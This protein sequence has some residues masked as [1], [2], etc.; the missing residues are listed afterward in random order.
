M[1]A[2][3]HMLSYLT[4]WPLA[5][6]S[7]TDESEIAQR[8]IPR[9]YAGHPSCCNPSD[10]PILWTSLQIICEKYLDFVLK[11]IKNRFNCSL[12]L[13]FCWMSQSTTARKDKLVTPHSRSVAPLQ[14]NRVQE[15]VWYAFE[16]RSKLLPHFY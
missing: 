14:M 10:L 9:F 11:N 7:H 13:L 4:V 15:V 12:H 5:G 6:L 8:Y 16:Y 2:G 3:T 1:V